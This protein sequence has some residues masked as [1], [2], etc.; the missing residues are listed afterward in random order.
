M[1]TP[2]FIRFAVVLGAVVILGLFW[3]CEQKTANQKTTDRAGRPPSI[4]SEE[5]SPTPESAFDRAG[6][7]RAHP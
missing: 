5:A 3:W 4:T 1:K 7:E 2:Y 6:R